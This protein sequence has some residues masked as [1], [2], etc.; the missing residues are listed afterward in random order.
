[1]ER[2]GT[3]VWFLNLTLVLILEDG[4]FYVSLFFCLFVLYYLLVTFL[5]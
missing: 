2:E 1:M 4:F 5:L 3:S